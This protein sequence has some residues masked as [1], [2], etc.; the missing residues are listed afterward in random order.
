MVSV[1]LNM[2]S[3][4][5]TKLITQ[6]QDRGERVVIEEQGK[7]VAAI[8]TYTDLKRLEAIEAA[9]LKKVELEEYEW[10]RSLIRNP[11]FQFLNHPEEDIYTLD[12]GKPF[13]DPE[14]AKSVINNPSF[15]FITDPEEDIYTISDGKPFHD[16]G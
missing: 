5:L 15:G 7:A 16:Q 9:L 14:W 6:I 12:D 13:H 10:L 3:D 4:S 11:A 2:V 1:N 8:I